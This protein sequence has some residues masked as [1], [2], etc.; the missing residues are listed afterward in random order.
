MYCLTTLYCDPMAV[1]VCKLLPLNL[2][3]EPDTPMCNLMCHMYAGDHYKHHGSIFSRV[4]L[5][6]LHDYCGKDVLHS[7]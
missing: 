5:R 4:Q 2:D 6:L 3:G 7:T 1:I